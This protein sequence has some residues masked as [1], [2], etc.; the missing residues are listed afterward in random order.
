[1][2]PRPSDS[3]VSLMDD[4]DMVTF[5]AL[6][7]GLNTLEFS[8]PIVLTFSVPEGVEDVGPLSPDVFPGC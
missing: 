1:M 7:K 2:Q 6:P 4:R 3:L 5:L 8:L